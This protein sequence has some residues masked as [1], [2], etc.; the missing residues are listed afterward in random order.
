MALAIPEDVREHVAERFGLAIDPDQGPYVPRE[1]LVELAHC[2]KEEFGFDY[3]VYCA[4]AH[5]P[6]TEE[7]PE[8]ILVAYR[9]RRFGPNGGSFPLRIEVPIHETT[10]SL[11]GVWAGADWQER[12]Q[13]DLVGVVFTDHPDLRKIMMPED[14]PGHPLRRDYA[15][16]TRHFPWR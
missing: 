5:F 16:D 4:A 7:K 6:G 12:E 9:V 15:I 14:W 11:A 2:I 1:R 3:L 10:P 8:H 13:F